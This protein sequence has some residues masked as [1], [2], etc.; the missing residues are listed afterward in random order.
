V[1]YLWLQ[2]QGKAPKLK[3]KKIEPTIK[4]AAKLDSTDVRDPKFQK[5][6]KEHYQKMLDAVEAADPERVER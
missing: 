6:A 5:I 3:N 4:K 2:E 1:Q